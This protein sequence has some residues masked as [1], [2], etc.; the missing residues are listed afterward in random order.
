MNDI[1][2]YEFDRQG[3]IIIE[4]MLNPPEVDSLAAAVDKLETHALAHVNQ[5]PRKKSAWGPEYHHNVDRGY[6]TQGSNEAGRTL[7]IEDFWNADARFDLLVNHARTMACIDAIVQDRPTVNNSELRI[8][9]NGNQSG[10]HGGTRMAG[11]KYRYEYNQNGI[12][13]MMVRMI[14]FVHD[15]SNEQGAFCVVP[16]THKTNLPCPYGHNPDEE[17]GMIGLEVKAGDA[18][19]FTENLRHGGVTNRSDQVRKTIHV[20]YGPHWMMSQNIATM[21]EPPYITEPT[22]KR[23]DEAQRALFQA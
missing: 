7:M 17:P 15:V 14:Y 13:C 11:R 4:Q 10:T 16:G 20:G 6:Y 3:Y 23:W 8:R 22:M 21:D 1:E 5:P 18:I 12:D 2:R 9:Y 19:L